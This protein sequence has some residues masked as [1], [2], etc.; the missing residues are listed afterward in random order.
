[1]P[2][3]SESIQTEK[4]AAS[5]ENHD[6]PENGAK[7]VDGDFMTSLARGLSVIQAFSQHKR[8]LTVSQISILTGISRAA[9]RRCLHT[10]SK[11]GFAGTHDQQ[12]YYLRPKVLSL[13]Q[14]YFSS[15]P[16]GKVAQPVLDHLSTELS[17]SCSVATLEDFEVFYIA[18]AAVS[19]IIAI[20][21]RVG[22]RLPAYCTSMGRVLLAYL[23]PEEVDAY[24]ARGPFPPRTDRTVVSV[25]KLKH[26]LETVRRN[27]YALVDQELEVGL[28]SLAVPIRA[29][30]GEVV[31]ALNVGCHAQR[32]SVREMQTAFL[33]LLRRAATE[34]GN[35]I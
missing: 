20:D 26:V 24:L 5:E 12:H 4:R 3:R 13:G 18:R 22:S 28:R 25:A 35:L 34:I 10:L 19:R 6:S 23:R 16:L 21:L 14:A 33:P 8:Q 7:E 31:A 27:E 2:R 9:V 11:L 32:T 29:S 1:M 30:S 17:E 15:T